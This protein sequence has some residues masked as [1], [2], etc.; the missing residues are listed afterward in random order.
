MTARFLSALLVPVLALAACSDRSDRGASA[1][2]DSMPA[3]TDS[4]GMNEMRSDDSTMM[5]SD[6]L[7]GDSA[8]RD[9]SS[10]TRSPSTPR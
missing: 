8:R 1:A 5:R 10:S 4:V 7:I 2:L 6:S 3:A 9:T